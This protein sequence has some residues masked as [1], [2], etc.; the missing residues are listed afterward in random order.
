VHTAA[1]AWLA[2]HPEAAGLELAVEAAGVHGRRVERVP[3]V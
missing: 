3:L 1:R 2:A